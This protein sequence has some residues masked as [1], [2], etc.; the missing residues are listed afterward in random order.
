MTSKTGDDVKKFVMTSKTPFHD[1]LFP[2]KLFMKKS[3]IFHDNNK[4]VMTYKVKLFMTSQSVSCCQK[5]HF[6]F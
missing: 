3:K 1:I 4:F 6:R 5:F 2:K